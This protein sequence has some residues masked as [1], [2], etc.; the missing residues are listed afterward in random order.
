M[1]GGTRLLILTEGRGGV[2]KRTVHKRISRTPPTLTPPPPTPHQ[3]NKLGGVWFFV[4]CWVEVVC[5]SFCLRVGFVCLFLGWGW[6]GFF[7]VGGYV[8]LDMWCVCCFFLEGGV[9]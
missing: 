8:V 2:G 1:K 7:G 3:N 5:F 9:G 6:S 4:V